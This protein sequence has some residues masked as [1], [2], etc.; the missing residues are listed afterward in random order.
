MKFKKTLIFGLIFALCI[1]C[2]L[3]QEA[4]KKA[5]MIIAQNNF[6][7]D[8]F[9]RPKAVLEE[10]GIDV[11][12]ASTSL[13]EATGMLGAKVKPDILVDE[14]DV[15][16]FDII[17]FVGGSGATQYLDD[18][19]AHE[20]AR[21]GIRANRIVAAIC[22]APVILANAGI[23]EGKQATV[24]PSEGDRIEAKGADYTGRPVEIDG[25]IITSSGPAAAVE[26]GEEIIKALNR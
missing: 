24:W 6:Q 7:D 13:D 16:N 12:V 9:L 25:N 8:E 11:T 23:L 5:V 18:P 1:S 4:V 22:I 20:I 17:V 2:V 15:N 19:M 10:N 14:V 26:F 3:A 21:D